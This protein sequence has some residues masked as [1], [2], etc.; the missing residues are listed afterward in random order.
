[1]EL[2][3]VPGNNYNF[4]QNQMIDKNEAKPVSINCSN[5]VKN[6]SNSIKDPTCILPIS[7]AFNIYLIITGDFTFKPL[8]K[9]GL[10]CF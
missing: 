6:L 4:N 3:L 10:I 2:E 5:K 8:Y 1:M 7:G 9:C